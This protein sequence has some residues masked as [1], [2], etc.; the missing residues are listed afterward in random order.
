MAQR[1]RK[2]QPASLEDQLER[3]AAAA[4]KIAT[5]RNGVQLSLPELGPALVLPVTLPAS[6]VPPKRPPTGGRV[7]YDVALR[8]ILKAM[9]RTLEEFGEQWDDEARQDLVSTLF[10]AAHK[11]KKISFP[12]DEEAA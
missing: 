2:L 9:I 11:E 3:T 7:P 12:F 6:T 1:N 8:Q 10:I 4:P 5:Y